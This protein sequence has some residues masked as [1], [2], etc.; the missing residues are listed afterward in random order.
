[1]FIRP[2]YKKSN[3]KKVA[4]GKRKPEFVQAKLFDDDELEPQWVEINANVVRVEN[5][6]TFGG[7]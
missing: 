5:E 2:C 6:K 1:M 7:S 4:E 3:G